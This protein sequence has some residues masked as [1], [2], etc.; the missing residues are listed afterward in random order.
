MRFKHLKKSMVC[1]LSTLMLS[2][3][4]GK[5]T[6]IFAEGDTINDEE[7]A[8]ELA[9]IDPNLDEYNDCLIRKT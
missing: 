1:C 2:S 8:E 5:N 4:T 7:F 3:F 9:N 6:T